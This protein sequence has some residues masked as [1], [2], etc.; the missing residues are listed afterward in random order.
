MPARNG[1]VEEHPLDPARTPIKVRFKKRPKKT[2]DAGPEETSSHQPSSNTDA[3]RSRSQR[4]KRKQGFD[5]NEVVSGGM[6]GGLVVRQVQKKARTAPSD[7]GNSNNAGTPGPSNDMDDDYTVSSPAVDAVHS[8]TTAPSAPPAPSR[9]RKRRNAKREA[10]GRSWPRWLTTI[11][12]SL[13]GPCLV[14][15]QRL[16]SGL[17][18][19]PIPSA[20]NPPAGAV[21]TP[22]GFLCPSCQDCLSSS[23]AVIHCVDFTSECSLHKNLGGSSYSYLDVLDITSQT[24]LYC[25]KC[26]PLHVVLAESGFF[27]SA[28]VRPSVAFSFNILEFHTHVSPRHTTPVTSTRSGLLH[29]LKRHGAT[30]PTKVN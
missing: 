24:V 30:L 16:A 1:Q 28:S 20:Q 14:V 21:A 8:P 9:R 15:E 18:L 3:S 23:S 17:P 2:D 22:T 6:G 25:V 13:V 5:P 19:P 4:S 10:K 7:P 27:A 29:L 12:P 26:K 11:I